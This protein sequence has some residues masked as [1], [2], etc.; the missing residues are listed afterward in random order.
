MADFKEKSIEASVVELKLKTYRAG[1]KTR[2]RDPNKASF[3]VEETKGQDWS[4]SLNRWVTIHRIIN[5]EAD[6]YYELVVDEETGDVLRECEERLTDH[7]G[8]GTAKR[9]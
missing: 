6:I 2:H 8:R 4:V 7:I 1:I 5:R 9:K 3:K